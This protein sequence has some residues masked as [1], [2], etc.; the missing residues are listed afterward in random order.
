MNPTASRSPRRTGWYPLTVT[1]REPLTE[2][3][4][5]VT[6]D[7]PSDLTATFA[8]APG[9]HVVVRHRRPGREL[10]RAYSVCPPPG[11]PGALRLV[12]QRETPDGFGAHAR[13]ALAVGDTLEL[14]PPT[15]TF[16]L[17]QIPGAHHVLIAGGSGITPLAAMAAAALR[18][19][20]GCR[21]SLVH[22]ARTAGT[23]LLADEL[24]E[25]KDAFVDR[26]TALYVLSRERRESDL[27]TGRI[28]ADRLRR[29]LTLLDARPDRTTT[30]SL[31]GPWGLVETAR[32]AL[33][34]WGA[35]AGAV[36]RELFS[37]DGARPDPAEGPS[38][39]RGPVLA[40]PTAG[41]SRVRAVIGGRTTAVTM[42]PG[43]R[44]VLDP[45]LRA[46]PEVPYACRDGVCGSCRALVVSGEVT[47]GRQ[48]ALDPRDLAAGYTLAC[49][50]RP[51]TPDLT[52]D[53][54]A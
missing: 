20:P 16:G 18:D 12:I 43:D 53:F 46:R 17:P 14:A 22:A 41:S 23:A 26:F 48:H 32:T 45:V 9:R 7:V 6:L 11:D 51:A 1:R 50:A 33:T 34:A 38:D 15:G 42:A 3:A 4:V 52:L 10:R 28:D 30:F 47:L 29:L 25:L 2:D 35:P 40:T 44:V 49:R 21:V 36:R 19:D 37:A 8:A 39:D 13:T 5:A 24:A 54:D 27:F 31:C